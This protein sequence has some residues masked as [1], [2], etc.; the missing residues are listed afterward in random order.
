MLQQNEDLVHFIDD[1]LIEHGLISCSFNMRGRLGCGGFGGGGI[2]C[3]LGFC[4]GLGFL[5]S[6]AHVHFRGFGGMNPMI[7]LV[8]L[9]KLL[10]IEQQAAE[11][12]AGSQLELGIHLDGFKGQTSTQIWQLMQTEMSISKRVG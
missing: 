2:G 8:R 3:G 10:A 6:Q 9:G 5:F 11:A 4:V 7:I 12:I 1:R